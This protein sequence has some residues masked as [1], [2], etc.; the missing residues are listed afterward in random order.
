MEQPERSRDSRLIIPGKRPAASSTASLLRQ[1]PNISRMA[2][3]IKDFY[4]E[5][6]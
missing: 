6:H 1:F 2:S 5:N 4:A 3:S